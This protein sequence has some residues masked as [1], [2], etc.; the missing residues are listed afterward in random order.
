MNENFKSQAEPLVELVVQR[1]RTII[2]GLI[3]LY[4]FGS[5][6]QGTARPDSDVDLALLA[7]EAL[8]PASLLNLK[9]DLAA[10][11]HRETDVIDLRVAPTVL[12]MQVLSTGQCLFSGDDRARELFEAMVYSSYVRL[13]EE[14]RAILDDVRVRGTVYAG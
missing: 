12:R 7:P 9:E 4:R 6:A 8:S 13:N 11:L 1:V 5:Q 3:A 14:R 2:P 10:L